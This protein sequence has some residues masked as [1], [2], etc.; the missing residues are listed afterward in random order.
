MVISC[1]EFTGGWAKFQKGN[2][3]KGG[4]NMK[5]RSAP[6]SHYEYVVGSSLKEH[7]SCFLCIISVWP[8]F[9]LIRFYLGLHFLLI[10]LKEWLFTF[11]CLNSDHFYDRLYWGQML[12]LYK[13][14]KQPFREVPW[15]TCFQ[16]VVKIL[17]WTTAQVSFKY[18]V[19]WLSII[20][21]DFLEFL[22]LIS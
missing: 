1:C 21:Y 10:A 9:C 5:G 2:V 6:F 14:Q 18:F 11:P 7:R 8:L 17:Q 12:L 4:P 13:I 3:K 20:S 19:H 16:E 22:I 15:N